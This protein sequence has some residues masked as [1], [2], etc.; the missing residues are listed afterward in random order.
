[1]KAKMTRTRFFRSI[2]ILAL[3]TAFAGC[4]GAQPGAPGSGP[5]AAAGG[6]IP[7]ESAFKGAA[8]DEAASGPKPLPGG[9]VGTGDSWGD[10]AVFAV[11]GAVSRCEQVSRVA[12]VVKTTLKGQLVAIEQGKKVEEP[13]AAPPTVSYLRLMDVDGGA[14]TC[15]DFKLDSEGR[16]EGEIQISDPANVKPIV[17]MVSLFGFDNK[18][19]DCDPQYDPLSSTNPP[20]YYGPVK[21]EID[22]SAFGVEDL[23]KCGKTP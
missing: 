23:P 5:L 11:Q 15:T 13:P 4:L 7:S 22:F 12:T 8:P 20:K 3:W 18:H 19:P 21:N 9:A 10:D 17:F 2:L 1:M 16:F 6:D 14:V